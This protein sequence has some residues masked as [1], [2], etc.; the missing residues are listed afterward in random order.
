M[1]PFPAVA[2][3]FDPLAFDP[4]ALSVLLPPPP[5]AD[6]CELASRQAKADRPTKAAQLAFFTAGGN[7][8]N[9]PLGGRC[10]PTLTDFMYEQCL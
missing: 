2:L 1:S 5:Q 7:A 4:P 9:L 3:E 8:R 6:N 10:A